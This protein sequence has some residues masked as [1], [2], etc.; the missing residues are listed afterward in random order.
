MAPTPQ[1]YCS[2]QSISRSTAVGGRANPAPYQPHT[3]VAP[4][5]DRSSGALP[6]S[7]QLWYRW[8]VLKS[9]IRSGPACS[10]AAT[11]APIRPIF[12]NGALA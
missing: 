4:P 9:R 6:L 3:A 1:K 7:A 12:F 8:F 5:P 10:R 11:A 2:F